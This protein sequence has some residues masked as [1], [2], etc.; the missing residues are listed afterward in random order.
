MR[1][2]LVAHL[3][4]GLLVPSWTQASDYEISGNLRI[5][6][7]DFES[8]YRYVDPVAVTSLSDQD[9]RA[10]SYAGNEA[11]AR[12]SADHA[13]GTLSGFAYGANAF[14]E[15]LGWRWATAD[16]EVTL[17]DT[18]ALEVPVGSY[19]DGATFGVSGI[20]NGSL[21]SSG[22]DLFADA[23]VRWSIQVQRLGAPGYGSVEDSRTAQN[24]AIVAVS[25]PFA[26]AFQLLSPGAVL[27]A[28]MSVTVRVT[29]HLMVIAD[30]YDAFAVEHLIEQ[31]DIED[32]LEIR[33]VDVPPGTSWT[34]ASG[35]FLPEPG[36]AAQ[37]AAAVLAVVAL[38]QRR[39]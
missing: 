12:W 19:P 6:G 8:V 3:L 16:A 26:P 18:L 30:T 24:G 29:A 37:A 4:V 31:T 34:S 32:T 39:T 1:I 7:M 27:A 22:S 9:S 33:S 25:E 35:V 5:Q 38:R 14:A 2:P 36:S 11:S 10:G 13:L 15:G 28:P 17:K 23:T 21:Q 20:V